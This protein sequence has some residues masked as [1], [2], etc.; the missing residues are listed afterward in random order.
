MKFSAKVGIAVSVG[1]ILAGASVGVAHAASKTVAAP[2][3][4]QEQSNWCWV[5]SAK[6]LVRLHKG[7]NPA[8]CTLYKNAKGGTSCPNNVGTLGDVYKIFL[9]AGLIYA[10]DYAGGARSWAQ[11]QGDLNG[12]RPIVVR[13]GWTAGGGHMVVI[14]SYNTSGSNVGYMN[15]LNSAYQSNTYS[16]MV[17]GGGHTW[18]HSL[19]QAF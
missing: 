7:T 1:L 19:S 6:S 4:V 2:V 3:V 11:V 17:S 13:W 8:Q 5:A 18:T 12:N 9:A 15:P 10:G 16:W 14:R